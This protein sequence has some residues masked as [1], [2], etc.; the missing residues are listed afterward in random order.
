MSQQGIACL[1]DE[2]AAQVVAH[3]RESSQRDLFNNIAQGNFPKW[4]LKVQIMPEA[5]AETYHINPFDLTKVWP[6]AKLEITPAS[7]H[8]AFEAENVDAL[9]RATD[10]FA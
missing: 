4:T 7:G 2:E 8:S 6:K 10:G 9:V 1:T 3:D 5:E